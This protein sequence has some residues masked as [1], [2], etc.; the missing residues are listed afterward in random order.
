M[1]CASDVLKVVKLQGAMFYN[2]EFSRFRP[3]LDVVEFTKDLAVDEN[4]SCAQEGVHCLEGC[5]L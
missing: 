3:L 2:D 5:E 1:D 4:T